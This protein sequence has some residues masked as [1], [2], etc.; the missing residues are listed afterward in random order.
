MAKSYVLALRIVAQIRNQSA[1]M[2][3]LSQNGRSVREVTGSAVRVTL[4]SVGIRIHLD[5]GKKVNWVLAS[6]QADRVV[7]MMNS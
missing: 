2:H 5:N 7:A 3:W 4:S 6:A 1:V